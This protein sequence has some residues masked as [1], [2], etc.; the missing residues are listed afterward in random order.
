[1]LV[2][3]LTFQVCHLHK[4]SY[5]IFSDK[6]DVFLQ[7]GIQCGHITEFSGAPGLGKTQLC[8]QLALSSTLHSKAYGVLYIDSE[9][10][11]SASRYANPFAI[12]S[13]IY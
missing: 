7:G 5:V 11:F 13:S 6:L 2:V 3:Y 10:A 4:P 9:G 1:M 8:L 12:V